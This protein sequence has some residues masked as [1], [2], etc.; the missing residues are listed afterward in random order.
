V[1]GYYHTKGKGHI[2]NGLGS[3]D[4]IAERLSAAV[5]AL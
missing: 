2:I 3:I 4:E 1:F 5:D